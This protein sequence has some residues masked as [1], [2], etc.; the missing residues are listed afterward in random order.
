MTPVVPDRI[1]AA[2][3]TAEQRAAWLDESLSALVESAA[4]LAQA[5]LGAPVSPALV[6]A[7]YRTTDGYGARGSMDAL[8]S[9]DRDDLVE[10]AIQA[11]FPLEAPIGFAHGSLLCSAALV[12][13]PRCIRLLARLGAD[14][15]T[16]NDHGDSPLELACWEAGELWLH[17]D[18]ARALVL[19][20][21][22][23]TMDSRRAARAQRLAATGNPLPAKDIQP[24]GRHALSNLGHEWDDIVAWSARHGSP[25][26]APS[27]A[28]KRL[29]A[30]RDA[31]EQSDEVFFGLPLGE[32]LRLVQLPGDIESAWIAQFQQA[33]LQA[34]R[35]PA[36]GSRAP[37]RSAI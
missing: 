8:L 19:A 30:L 32:C 33:S 4:L 2:P 20:G 5:A 13:A 24:L 25:G 34:Q 17:V 29:R 37:R 3:A 16:L 12:G 31:L 36:T 21:A 1:Y 11:G 14:L 28:A 26:Q 6:Q 27:A 23:S 15:D 35:L 22:S 10:A 9:S 18:C 7:F